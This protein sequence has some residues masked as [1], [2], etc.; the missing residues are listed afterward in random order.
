VEHIAGTT[1]PVRRGGNEGKVMVRYPAE[2]RDTLADLKGTLTP[3]A[4][5]DRLP[6]SPV[7]TIE[8]GRVAANLLRHDGR[9][10]TSV[11]A[12]LGTA[13]AMALFM[14]YALLA[15]VF[16][17]CVQP[18][19]V[20]FAGRARPVRRDHRT[21]HHRHSAHDPVDFGI[22]WLAGVVIN[23]SPVTVDP[24]TG[25]IRD[26]MPVQAAV[27][28]GPKDRFRPILLTSLATSPGSTLPD[29]LTDGPPLVIPGARV[30]G[31][32]RAPIPIGGVRVIA[33][34]P[35]HQRMNPIEQR[36]PLVVLADLVGLFA[37][38]PDLQ[39][40]VR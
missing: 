12:A 2:Q 38:L 10:I 37:R 14:I 22:I 5:G 36:G 20:V 9:Q 18:V 40:P 39:L 4:A 16:R 25:E 23:N 15:R 1:T 19:V 13:L 24:L 21:L 7:A 34:D 30:P 26:G 8:E 33:L 27:M 29:S 11:T 32:A 31:A 3:T 28:D 17:P 35:V 6:L